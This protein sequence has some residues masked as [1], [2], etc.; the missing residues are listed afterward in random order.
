[1]NWVIEDRAW[2]DPS[3]MA[4]KGLELGD[5]LPLFFLKLRPS[6]V[7]RIELHGGCLGPVHSMNNY[8][9]HFE[10]ACS[11]LKK[12]HTLRAMLKEKQLSELWSACKS[13]FPYGG[14]RPNLAL[15]AS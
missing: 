8:N 2:V 3:R 1:M 13:E 11:S 5:A 15:R 9:Y 12:K 7:F 6:F 14:L 10:N 4:F